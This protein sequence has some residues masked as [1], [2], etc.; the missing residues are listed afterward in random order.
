MVVLDANILMRAVLGKGARALLA[1]YGARIEFVAPDVVFLAAQKRLPAVIER[2]QLTAAP[3]MD[4]F[5]SLT[6]VV[7]TIDVEA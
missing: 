4:Y 3:F 5:F 7:Q 2:R 1:R 6:S